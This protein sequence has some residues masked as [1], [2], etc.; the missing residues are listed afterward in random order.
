MST[1]KKEREEE[2]RD[3]D[4]FINSRKEKITPDTRIKV[5]TYNVRGMIRAGKREMLELWASKEKI[6]IILIQETH[7]NQAGVE[8]RKNYTIFQRK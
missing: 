1:L 2:L 5:A 4:N 3:A 6:D 8:K 7:I